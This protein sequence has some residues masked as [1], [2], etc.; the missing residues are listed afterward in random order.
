MQEYLRETEFFDVN[1][2]F[3]QDTIRNL[4]LDGL[5][6][7][8]VAKKL[9]Y[10]V[11]DSIRY[12]IKPVNLEKITYTAS[13]VL[14]QERSFCIPKAIALGTLARAAG[15]PS[16]IHFVDFINHRLSDDLQKMWGTKVMAAHCYTELYLDNKWV[17]ATPALDKAICDR[18]N[19]KTVEF[20]GYTD[21]LLHK[22]DRSG[23]PHAEYIKDRGTQSDMSLRLVAEVFNEVYGGI[24]EDFMDEN[25][26]AA[27][28]LFN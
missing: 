4:E 19:F 12:S 21:A 9:F 3:I 25:F 17:K 8:E 20:D 6:D 22:V 11:R 13:H 15:I 26:K 1:S 28:T 14:Q 2:K 5:S 24:N 10:H 23:N 16:R 7:I 18:H 27:K